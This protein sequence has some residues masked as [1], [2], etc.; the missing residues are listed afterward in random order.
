MGITGSTGFPACGPAPS[1]VRAGGAGVPARHPLIP[2]F[3]KE[4]QEGF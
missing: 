3:L 4:G 1:V 2:L